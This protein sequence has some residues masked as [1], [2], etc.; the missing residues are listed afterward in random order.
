MRSSADYLVKLWSR[1]LHY[2]L[3]L[4]FLFFVWLFAFTGLLLNHGSWQFAEFWPN[5]K[6]SNFERAIEPPAYG[7]REEQAKAVMRQL[8]IHGEIQWGSTT[9]ERLEFQVNRPG[10]NF[11]VK[12][13]LGQRLARVE[14]TD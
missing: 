8:G 6:V 1:K 13:D 14:R 3:G 12:A 4:Y 2:Y 11:A 9:E 5:R 7:D 10:Q